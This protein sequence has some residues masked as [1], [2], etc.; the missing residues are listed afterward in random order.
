MFQHLTLQNLLSFGPEGVGVELR[1]LNVLIGTNGAGKSNFIDAISLLEAAPQAPQSIGRPLFQGGGVAQ[2]M[3]KGAGAGGACRLDAVL[4]G[5]SA[6]AKSLRYRV[7]FGSLNGRF[8]LIDEVVENENPDLPHQSDVRFFYR[9][10]NGRPVL[11][12]RSSGQQD[13]SATANDGRHL[14][15]DLNLDPSQS[16]LAQRADPE[17]FPEISHLGSQFRRIAIYRNWGFGRHTPA[18]LPQ[19]PDLPSEHLLPDAANLALVLNYLDNFNEV[20]GEIRRRLREFN[21]QFDGFLARIDGGTVQLALQVS[22]LA[23]ALPATRLSDGTLRYLALMCVLC[24]PKP[25]PVIC[26][27]EPEIGLHPDIL[28][29]VAEMLVQASANTQLIVTT[30]SDILIDALSDTPENVLVCESSEK[31]TQVRR[32]NADALKPWL[33]D[34]SLGALWTRGNL[35]GNRW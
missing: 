25:P 35:G 33:T 34:Y 32:L 22:G 14:R 3:W 24:H 30:H 18:R 6:H 31:G 23:E 4:S 10:Q 26:L 16:I 9:F 17:Q 5:P 12:V 29:K 20:R 13:W 7:E 21:P 27:E 15:Q 8:N 2:W 28:P 19:Q 11:N 1:P